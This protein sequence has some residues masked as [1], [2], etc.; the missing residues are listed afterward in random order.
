MKYNFYSISSISELL[1]NDRKCFLKAVSLYQP[2]EKAL[3]KTKENMAK[4]GYNNITSLDLRSI[5]SYILNDRYFLKELCDKANLKESAR[6]KTTYSAQEI[7]TRIKELNSK[8]DQYT[9]YIEDYNQQVLARNR[10]KPI[11]QEIEFLNKI[12]S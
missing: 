12:I 11:Y 3:I 4:T 7:N 1:R 9:E 6:I 8:I 5:S 10:N 2:T